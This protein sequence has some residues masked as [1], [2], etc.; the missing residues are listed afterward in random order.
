[1]SRAMC[2]EGYENITNIDF[3]VTVISKMKAKNS[4]ASMQWVDIDCVLCAAQSTANCGVALAE[5]ARVLKPGGKF[6]S[7]S[8]SNERAINYDDEN[9][10]WA[11]YSEVEELAKPFVSNVPLE[12]DPNYYLYTCTR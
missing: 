2:D 7:V 6:F 8:Y 5:C 11:G 1:M 4:R 12:G 10:G 9:L 3:S